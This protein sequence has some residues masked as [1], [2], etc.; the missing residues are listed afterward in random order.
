MEEK[1]YL[2][3]A[4]TAEQVKKGIEEVVEAL[5]SDI[6]ENNGKV[7]TLE[8]AE[9]LNEESTA[10][11]LLEGVKIRLQMVRAIAPIKVNL[12]E[13]PI[14]D[15][16]DW[17]R[18]SYLYSS[19]FST[20]DAS[21]G[22]YT[23]VR[24]GPDII[25]E[26]RIPYPNGQIGYPSSRF[27][28]SGNPLAV[29]DETNISTSSDT[30]VKANDA[31]TF[32]LTL[33]E[34]AQ[35]VLE[36][37]SR[38]NMAGKAHLTANGASEVR[39]SD[40]ACLIADSSGLRFSQDNGWYN[41]RFIF[42]NSKMDINNGAEVY[43]HNTAQINID[44]G[45]S[46]DAYAKLIMHGACTINMDD[47]K[48]SKGYSYT[49]NSGGSEGIQHATLKIH[50]KACLNLNKGAYI[51]GSDTAQ[52]YFENDS[53]FYMQGGK[54]YMN[55][56]LLQ[57]NIMGHEY[58]PCICMNGGGTLLFN[59]ND[60]TSSSLDYSHG[61]TDYDPCLIA[62]PTS[63]VFMGQGSKGA[64]SYGPDGIQWGLPRHIFIEEGFSIQDSE[65]TSRIYNIKD[66]PD[67][68]NQIFV[69]II[70]ATGKYKEIRKISN[71]SISSSALVGG[72]YKYT[73]SDFFAETTEGSA[74]TFGNISVLCPANKN[75][76][77]QI[78][79][80]TMIIIDAASGLG[81]NY[82]KIGADKNSLLQISL[83]G[84]I[85][86]QMEHNS[87]S[88]MH[89]NSK[90]IMRGKGAD[91]GWQEKSNI[92]YINEEYSHLGQDWTRPV[93]PVENDSPVLG[94]Y[95]VAQFTMRGVWNTDD[96]W[97]LANSYTLSNWDTTLPIPTS[98]EE[99][100]EEF[101][102][103]LISASGTKVRDYKDEDG[104]ILT[105]FTLTETNLKVANYEY[106]TK[107]LDW[108]EHLDKIEDQPVVEII[109]NADVRIYGNSEL[110]LT[111]YSI[112][113]NSEGFTFKDNSAGEE[114][115][116]SISELKELKKLLSGATIIE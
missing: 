62:N 52:A 97:T 112:V 51:F 89:H 33:A 22:A 74:S 109:E 43:I 41:G 76:R 81:A 14:G 113:A 59:A 57:F 93:R 94:I 72:G 24:F 16:S 102:Q 53:E 25:N 45:L 108:N 60:N 31:K 83:T 77:I 105:T 2:D 116:F 47:G 49:G 103:K 106:S 4:A 30:R 98:V 79:D 3:I 55:G 88:E 104:N 39:F 35:A 110:K 12:G 68:Y 111:D 19:L 44:G 56:G 27:V 42:T 40:Q 71:G 92:W 75:P 86:Q 54:M 61:A 64:G 26:P 17:L 6:L 37:N 99:L 84:N 82:I 28:I 11:E 115:S 46:R 32:K 36:D 13:I 65:A 21:N 15:G 8:V 96:N 80:E 5:T 10:E 63:L 107:P 7:F 18:K 91:Y 67:E 66:L 70:N 50:D 34:Q 38:F 101:K 73:I 85:F 9:D 23:E 90:F 87:H 20:S 100:P 29:E 58:E 78:A 1:N 114:V 69:N 48:T 95:D